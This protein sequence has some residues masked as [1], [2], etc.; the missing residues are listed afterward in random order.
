MRTTVFTV[1]ALS[2]ASLVS[3]QAFAQ[4][5]NG[6]GNASEAGIGATLSVTAVATAN[7]NN[8][9]YCGGTPLNTAV[10]AHGFGFSTVLGPLTVLLQKTIEVNPP[11]PAMH[12]CL[13]L[14]SPDGADS[15]V[16][17]YD[18]TEQPPN[19]NGFITDAQ[20]TLTVT[21]AEG[22]FADLPTQAL[23]F[24]AVFFVGQYPTVTGYY[25]VN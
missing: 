24:N 8:V 20:G 17:T 10:E 7:T 21:K 14:T 23:Q 19:A 2:L 25:S 3:T 4:N 6:Q 16:L 22:K 12:G 13:T 18:G 5:E 11:G 9:A 15:L 1:A